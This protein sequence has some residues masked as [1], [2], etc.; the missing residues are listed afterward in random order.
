MKEPAKKRDKKLV[1]WDTVGNREILVEI[2][3]DGSYKRTLVVFRVV[4]RG[5]HGENRATTDLGR[6]G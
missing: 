1:K 3:T 5:G 2:V 4:W 6:L